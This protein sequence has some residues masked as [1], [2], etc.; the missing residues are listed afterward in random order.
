MITEMG[1]SGHF[2]SPSQ[3]IFANFSFSVSFY[4]KSEQQIFHGTRFSLV[5]SRIT[6]RTILHSIKMTSLL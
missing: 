1:E 6:K 4:K 3:D 5:F 2:S